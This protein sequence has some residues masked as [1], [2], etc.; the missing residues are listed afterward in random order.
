MDSWHL[1]DLAPHSWWLPKYW[2]VTSMTTLQMYGLSA[3]SFTKCWQVMHPSQ[4]LVSPIWLRILQGERTTSQRLSASPFKVFPSW[5]RVSNTTTLRDHHW[6]SLWTTLTSLLMIHLQLAQSR[7]CS[8]RSIH[9]RGS[10]NLKQ[11][12][13]WIIK[14]LVTVLM[15]LTWVT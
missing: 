1:R 14:P 4:A 3:V 6:T 13:H 9:R 15:R 12:T 2:T 5:T 8:F 7:T 10:S 11:T